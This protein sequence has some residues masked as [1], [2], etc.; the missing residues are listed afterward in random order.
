MDVIKF[1]DRLTAATTEKLARLIPQQAALNQEPACMVEFG[2][3]S[4]GIVRAA[5]FLPAGMIILG[6]N[7]KTHVE[8]ASHLP[9][10]S[11][12]DVVC[13]VQCP[14]LTLRSH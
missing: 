3:P 11:A 12:Y 5:T 6:L 2:E 13:T 1:R 10:S 8:T 4:E 7:H 14:V 9:W